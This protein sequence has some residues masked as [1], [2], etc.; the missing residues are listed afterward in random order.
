[1]SIWRHTRHLAFLFA[2]LFVFTACQD[3]DGPI[4]QT[5]SP[6]IDVE[7]DPLSNVVIGGSVD[8]NITIT[9]TG[10]GP[11]KLDSLSINETGDNVQEVF[12]IQGEERNWDTPQTV[13]AGE[14]IDLTVRFEPANSDSDNAE[15]VIEHNVESENGETRQDINL[16]SLSAEIG[17]GG[18]YDRATQSVSF[19]GVN[20][21]ESQS[22]I[23]RIDSNGT[24]FLEISRMGLGSNPRFDISFPDQEAAANNNSDPANDIPGED[25]RVWPNGLDFVDGNGTIPP[26]RP[27]DDDIENEV[28]VRITF[29]PTDNSVERSVLTLETN[30]PNNPIVQIDLKGNVGSPC[31]ALSSESRLDFG[32]G[33]LNRTTSE[34]ITMENCRPSATL[35]IIDIQLKDDAGG[36]YA[37]PGD[38]LPMEVTDDND[39]TTWVLGAET[40]KSFTVNF[41]PAMAGMEYNGTLE[42]E[43]TDPTKRNHEI[44]L[45]GEGTDNECPNAVAKGSIVDGSSRKRT[46]LNTLPLETVQLHS[47]E[48]TDDGTIERY[49][50]ALIDRPEDSTARLSDA[51]APSPTLFLD[52]AGTYK[53]ELTAYDDEGTRSCG[54]RAIV[55]I[56]AIPD[57]DVH[58][59]LVWDTPGDSDQTDN[60]GTD[61][62]LHYKQP[63]ANWNEAPGDIFWENKTAD[64]GPDG[65]PANPSL[66]IDDTDGAGPEN[67]NQ[68]KPVDDTEY[69]IGVFYFQDGGFGES[70]ATVRIYL[71]GV[72]RKEFKNKF[73][74]DTYDFWYVG[75]I[76]WGNRAIYPRDIVTESFP[77]N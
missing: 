12:A 40:R 19:D 59:Q 60:D 65:P 28:Y 3:T 5:E 74:E 69:Q 77:G 17:F 7:V 75:K 46:T 43:S 2:A 31:L 25:G 20:P 48:S 66:D 57:E 18:A 41:T 37:L 38:D 42:I 26:A 71:G 64:W 45:V 32:L 21:G 56:K 8:G 14:S 51:S 33:S 61:L 72:L 27:G 30:D 35:E 24:Y 16:P 55:T 58:I 39:D 1:M 13:A 23:I 47:D 73:L 9:N 15:I 68:D 50:W 54:Q 29:T 4:Q 53:V 44:D 52:L 63:G 62:D 22:K 34:T 76:K 11:L 6:D 70:Y 67:I 49:S 10:E 36:I